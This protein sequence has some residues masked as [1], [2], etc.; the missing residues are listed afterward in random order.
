[1]FHGA[2]RGGRGLCGRRRPELS[3]AGEWRGHKGRN[4][5]GRGG[6]RAGG[7]G[8]RGQETKGQEKGA[9]FSSEKELSIEPNVSLAPLGKEPAITR[10]RSSS[11]VPGP[12]PPQWHLCTLVRL[13][14]P[15]PFQPVQA[16][17]SAH[18]F[19][20]LPLSNPICHPE[21]KE[22]FIGREE[23]PSKCQPVTDMTLSTKE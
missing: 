6:R 21:D 5:W 1:M 23:K 22:L 11:G 16:P 9:A 14:T 8:Q 18:L 15:P 10:F 17:S 13:T 7:L 4:R 2:Q 3:F 19:D 20:W 12:L